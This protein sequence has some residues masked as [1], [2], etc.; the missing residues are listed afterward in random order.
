M[1]KYTLY[2]LLFFSTN[3]IYSQKGTL[4]IIVTDIE[5]NK[6]TINAALYNEAGKS[7]FLKNVEA[8]HQKKIVKINNKKV[9]LVFNNVP[10]GT[11]AVSIF[12]DENTNMKLDR[13]SV[14]FPAEPWGISGNK[15]VMGPPK[16]NDGKFKI[17]SKNKT[18][19]IKMKSFL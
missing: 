4:K 3:I 13:T 5:S 1:K 18:I 16:F 19:K 11:Y 12:Q 8:A 10:Y 14:G 17:N 15:F 6:G 7:G 2:I 9:A